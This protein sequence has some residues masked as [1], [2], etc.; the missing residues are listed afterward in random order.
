MFTRLI[1][2]AIA[3]AAISV[4]AYAQE[5]NAASGAEGASDSEP[6]SIFGLDS[7]TEIR[8]EISASEWQKLQPPADTDW[9][10]KR[11][12]DAVIS[13]AIQG[14]NFKSDRSSRP[15]LAGYAGIDHQY[16]QADIRIGDETV[17]NVGVRYKGSGTFL[18]G[19]VEGKCSFKI[20]FNEYE[21]GGEFRGLKKFNLNNNISDPSYL[22]EALSYE[23]FREAGIA[24]PRV[25]WAHVNVIVGDDEPTQLGFYSIIEQV[26]KRFL[27]R[28]YGSSKGLLLKP[29][30]FGT[31]RYFGEDW[32]PYE[33]AYN[34]KTTATDQ[35]KKRLI[36]FAR[37]VQK[38]TDEEFASR[39]EE[40]LDMDQFLTFLSMNVL[41]S[42]MDSFLGGS[43]N[44]YAYLNPKSNRFELL[45]WDLDHSFG[46]FPLMGTPESRRDMS[47][48]RPG[49]QSSN[50]RVLERVLANDGFRD[51]YHRKLD[52]LLDTVFDEQKLQAQ[53]EVAGDFVRPLIHESEQGKFDLVL[54]EAPTWGEPHV[55]KYFVTKRTE[56]V[57]DQLSGKSTGQTHSYGNGGLPGLWIGIGM[58]FLIALGA[59]GLAWLFGL[60]AGFKG[61]N[62][63]GIAN[64]FL[65]PLSPMVFGFAVRRDL[66]LRSAIAATVALGLMI[67][68]LAWAVVSM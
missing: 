27:K 26:D 43:Q 8:I 60:F 6:V 2:V 59:N 17:A 62:G 41:L 57:R 21:K 7:V 14:R 47:I 30:T 64:M 32:T 58:A 31:F 36:E 10:I 1:A 44:Y 37:L 54:G 53:I 51:A 40:F 29:S 65:Y 4:P 39:V 16:G 12:L 19:Y 20:D 34:P 24:A 68:V 66:G 50:N 22:R 46:A 61:G 42:N 63:W 28:H 52:S 11:A 45:P 48:D 38:G 33:D 67:A 13:D 18:T 15:G 23:L 55:L 5:E 35:Q 9:D 49:A 25:G 56:S 3:L